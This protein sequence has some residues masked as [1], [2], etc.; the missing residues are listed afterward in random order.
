[1]GSGDQRAGGLKT[2]EPLE[3]LRPPPQ[4][5]TVG[6]AETGP[7]STCP[8]CGVRFRGESRTHVQCPACGYRL[9]GGL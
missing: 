2:A 5:L 8:K 7:V 9:L 6:P 4:P 3:R 1:M